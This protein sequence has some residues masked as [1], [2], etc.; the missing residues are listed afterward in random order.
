MNMK[1]FWILIAA[2]IV[3]GA[4]GL[5]NAQPTTPMGTAFT[6]QGRL[7]DAG[8]P[9]LGRY[10]FRFTAYSSPTAD[11]PFAGPIEILDVPVDYGMFTVAIDF[12][13]GVFTGDARWL[14]ID[15]RPSDGAVD[16]TTLAPRQ[17]LTPAPYAIYAEHGNTLDEAYD[18]GGP[19]A[20][21]TIFTDAGPVSIEGMD[22]ILINSTEPMGGI[23]FSQMG[24]AMGVVGYGDWCGGGYLNA[25]TI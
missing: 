23:H 7:F 22:G 8:M 21:R 3:L 4:P 18:E 1:R 11:T 16:Y 14:E 15:V 20:G 9:V 13:S 24:Q 2:L 10:D 5:V 12:G 6:Y 25:M 17:E 19:G